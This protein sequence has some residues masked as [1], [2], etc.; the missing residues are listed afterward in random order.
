[1]ND[2]RDELARLLPRPAER[3]L[4]GDR[5]QQLREALLTNLS[6]SEHS[7]RLRLRPLA[8]LVSGLAVCAAVAVAAIAIGG[9]PRPVT[10]AEQILLAAA[11]TAARTPE[12]TGAYWHVNVRSSDGGLYET[13]TARDGRTWFTY[14]TE[15]SAPA[16]PGTRPG[17]VKIVEAASVAPFSLGGAA[18]TLETIQ[19][20]PTE[21][22][23]LSAR[24]D[25]IIAAADVRTSAGV[26]TAEQRERAVLQSLVSLVSQLPA[27]PAVRAA[28]F[29]A[30]A[31]YPNV[32]N[33]DE[34]LLISFFAGEP[35]ARL[36]VDPTTA[37][38]TRTNV[39]VTADGGFLSAADGSTFDL[40]S[41]WTDA[42]PS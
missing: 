30:F 28:A 18:V 14:R 42:P 40:T 16:T 41:E 5:H 7:A 13:W 2:V 25:E 27:P 29:R 12:G 15:D 4:P 33:T 20:L 39:V 37:R 36:V 35:P 38:V 22:K 26:L 8:Y 19:T 10:S 17:P 1:M 11:T 9:G 23:A 32:E 21:E 6:T 31:A 34:G 3:D 24:I